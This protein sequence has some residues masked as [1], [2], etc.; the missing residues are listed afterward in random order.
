MPL[1]ECRSGDPSIQRLLH[2]QVHTNSQ[3]SAVEY[4]SGE[5]GLLHAD[6]ARRMGSETY[7]STKS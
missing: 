2:F 5:C 3:S 7:N 4:C 6:A 1:A